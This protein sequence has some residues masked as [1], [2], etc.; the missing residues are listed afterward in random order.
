MGDTRGGAVD[1]TSAVGA[2][3]VI[4]VGSAVGVSG[5]VGDGDTVDTTAEVRVDDSVTAVVAVTKPVR[6]TARVGE[7]GVASGEGE[8]DERGDVFV[9]QGGRGQDLVDRLVLLRCRGPYRGQDVAGH[10]GQIA[11]FAD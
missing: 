3:A 9:A 10:S 5:V 11:S 7:T 1:E 8:L 6:P 2:K 4:E